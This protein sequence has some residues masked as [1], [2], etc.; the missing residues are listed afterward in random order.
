MCT[1]R[2]SRY[3]SCPYHFNK[4]LEEKL[5]LPK[6]VI[7]PCPPWEWLFINELSNA[8]PCP[9]EQCAAAAERHLDQ[10]SPAI[11]AKDISQ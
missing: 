9:C 7:A 4:T 6:G 1:R 2:V 10:Q 3:T 8:E 5:C 11:K